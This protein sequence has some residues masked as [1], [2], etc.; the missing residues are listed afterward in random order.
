MFLNP[1]AGFQGAVP[2][3]RAHYRGGGPLDVGS[4]EALKHF[5]LTACRRPF[6]M[7]SAMCSTSPSHCSS[8]GFNTSRFASSCCVIIMPVKSISSPNMWLTAFDIDKSEVIRW[9]FHWPTC[10]V[11][12]LHV[13]YLGLPNFALRSRLNGNYC[14][15]ILAALQ[16]NVLYCNLDLT[17]MLSG[18]AQ[19]Q[20]YIG[21]VRLKCACRDVTTDGLQ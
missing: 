21:D 5:T 16:R 7:I 13:K 10:L 3:K 4:A 14:S 1:G 19:H 17:W 8:F 12:L 2:P 15:S 18:S 6:H 9:I 11:L 20:S